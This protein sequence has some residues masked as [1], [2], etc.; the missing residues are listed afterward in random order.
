MKVIFLDI[1]GV[2]N[3]YTTRA[4]SPMGFIGIDASILQIFKKVVDVTDA[5][6]VLTSAW[7]AG[8]END[9]ELCDE[10][11][12]YMVDALNSI[13]AKIINKTGFSNREDRGVKTYLLNHK[14]IESWVVVDDSRFPGFDKEPIVSRFVNTDYETGMT[15]EDAKKII[16]ILNRKE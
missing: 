13:G 1:D 7:Q 8:Y 16:Y 12:R 11:G 5:K 15:E 3:S 10:D 14:D 9:R 2:L 4:R 6:I